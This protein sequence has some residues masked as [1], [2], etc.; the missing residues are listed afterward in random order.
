M[1]HDVSKSTLTMHSDLLNVANSIT[2]NVQHLKN[3][4]DD[5]AKL[6]AAMY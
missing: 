1:L 3:A 4:K 6:M 2:N 5:E